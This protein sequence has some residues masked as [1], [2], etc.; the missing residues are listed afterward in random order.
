MEKEEKTLGELKKEKA[1]WN[2]RE[3]RLYDREKKNRRGLKALRCRHLKN[4]LFF[5]SGI[6]CCLVII[7]CAVAVVPIK[8]YLGLVG[9]DEKTSGEYVSDEITKKSA[10]AAILEVV[11]LSSLDQVGEVSPFVKNELDDVLS[12]LDKTISI[13]KEKL[14]ALDFSTLAGR[15]TED[16][17]NEIDFKVVATLESL[18]VMPYLGEFSELSIFKTG[19]PVYLD[20]GVTPATKGKLGEV[21]N[22]KLYVYEDEEGNYVSAANEKGDGWNEALLDDRPLYYISLA[23]AALSDVSDVF[24]D[25][26]D[27]VTAVEIVEL[28]GPVEENGV[29]KKLLKNTM[30]KDVGGLGS[31]DILL[32]DFVKR[33]EDDNVTETQIFTIIRSAYGIS[34]DKEIYLSDLSGDILIENVLLCDIM[35]KDSDATFF[36]ILED[37]LEKDYEQITVGDISSL[38][39]EKVK[40][41]TVLSE[42][43]ESYYNSYEVGS[44]EYEAAKKE[45]DNNAKLWKVIRSAVFVQPGEDVLI[46]DVVKNFDSGAIKISD[47]IEKTA[48]NQTFCDAV[49][50]MTGQNFEEISI[51]DFSNADTGE[52]KLSTIIDVK[53][54]GEEDYEAN[55]KLWAIINEAVVASDGENIRLKDLERG[56]NLQNVKISTVIDDASGN[57]FL[58]TLLNDDTVTV[59]NIAEKMDGLKLSDVYDVQCFTETVSEAVIF[60]ASGITYSYKKV[61]NNFVK[62][63]TAGEDGKLYYVSKTSG[64]WALLCYDAESYDADGFATK[65]TLSDITV[66]NIKQKMDSLTDKMSDL[67][68]RQLVVFGLLDHKDDYEK[69]DV[70]GVEIYIYTQ[71]LENA[72]GK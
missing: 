17:L 44:S 31:D 38:D 50:D 55:K 42:Y 46:G 66:G 54:V 2:K 43:D 12:R 10:A 61:G 20:D 65:Y 36:T 52:I 49:S 41:S 32:S 21:S 5:L 30:M 35:E 60:S 34:D 16:I 56:F 62:S 37:A 29:V 40:L 53:A 59:G 45:Y 25:R 1:E 63:D 70:L 48:D 58:K 72:I 13:D 51:N 3:K 39:I 57:L 9:V 18:E 33:Y 67:T 71:T 14:Y 28:W 22:Y 64:V 24:K 23:T 8:T 6:L 26:L 27:V 15:T 47:V 11:R 68:V 19:E 4:F 69:K 7:V